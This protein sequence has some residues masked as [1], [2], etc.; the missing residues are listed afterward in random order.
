LESFPEN[1]LILDLGAGRKKSGKNVLSIDLYKTPLV[2]LIGDIEH[3]PIASNSLDG[4]IARGVLEHVPCPG[5]VVSE[6]LRVLKPGGRVFSSIPFMQGYHPSPGDYRRY[7]LEG[8]KLLFSAFDE[9]ECDITRGSASSFVWIAREFLS[10]VLSLN[11]PILYKVFKILFGWMLQ[12][13]KYL[14]PV[15]ENHDKRHVAA[16]GFTFLGE[17][18]AKP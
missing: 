7:T 15:T 1:A 9:I 6:V 16:S 2:D 18:P 13:I 17:K 10:E 8:I 4:I 5:R 3:M 14:D 12:P 11:N